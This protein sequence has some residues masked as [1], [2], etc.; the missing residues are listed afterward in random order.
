MTCFA[1]AGKWSCLRTPRDSSGAADLWIGGSAGKNEFF[2][3]RIDEVR[4]YN[5]ALSDSEIVSLA[6]SPV[7]NQP[8]TATAGPDKSATV[9]TG[10]SVSGS[11]NVLGRRVEVGAAGHSAKMDVSDASEKREA[12]HASSKRR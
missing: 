7:S 4:I 2:A 12:H 11:V 6:E 5:R 10:V 3:G 8:P 1:L 9:N